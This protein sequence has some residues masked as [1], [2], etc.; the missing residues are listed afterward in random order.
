MAD[1]LFI[2]LTVVEEQLQGLPLGLSYYHVA[3]GNG[4][5]LQYSCMENPMDG[6]AW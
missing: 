6:G 4:T 3:E 5:P 2:I 1:F